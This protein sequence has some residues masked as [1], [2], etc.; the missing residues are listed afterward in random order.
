MGEELKGDSWDRTQWVI[1][2]GV[3]DFGDFSFL[4]FPGQARVTQRTATIKRGWS[5]S[6]AHPIQGCEGKPWIFTWAMAM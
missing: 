4:H 5:G 3:V 2:R 1:G 6:R